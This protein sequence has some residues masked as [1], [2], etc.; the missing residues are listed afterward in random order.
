M[1]DMKQSSRLNVEPC[2]MLLLAVYDGKIDPANVILTAEATTIDIHHPLGPSTTHPHKPSTL[3]SAPSPI[4]PRPK[5]SA[6]VPNPSLDL[7][8]TSRNKSCLPAASSWALL[9]A[10]IVEF[11]FSQIGHSTRS[12]ASCA[13]PVPVPEMWAVVVAGIFKHR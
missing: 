1:V 2:G 10:L 11:C 8:K 4:T 7:P 9:I 13:V 12:P 6:T 5:N 3:Y